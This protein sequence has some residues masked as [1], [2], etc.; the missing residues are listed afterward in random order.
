[1][2]H[3]LVSDGYPYFNVQEI[4]APLLGTYTALNSFEETDTVFPSQI[5]L[6]IEEVNKLGALIEGIES[7]NPGTAGRSGLLS[8]TSVGSASNA[9]NNLKVST[10]SFSH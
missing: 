3:E 1:M 5:K 7:S 8:A 10:L 4:W 9:T 2:V 6:I